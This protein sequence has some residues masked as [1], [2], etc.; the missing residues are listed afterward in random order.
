MREVV[1]VVILEVPSFL[2]VHHGQGLAPLADLVLIVGER[3]FTTMDQL[4]KTSDV[5]KRLGAPVVGLALTDPSDRDEDEDEDDRPPPRRR[6]AHKRPNDEADDGAIEGGSVSG[7]DATTVTDTSPFDVTTLVD[8]APLRF[9]TAAEHPAI[10]DLPG[11]P[12][13]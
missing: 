1:D 4:R 10:G 9:S 7:V 12:E 2:S 6:K 11:R 5:L 8:Q 3:R 13:A